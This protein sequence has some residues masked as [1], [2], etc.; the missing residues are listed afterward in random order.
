MSTNHS[1]I[2]RVSTQQQN[3]HKHSKLKETHKMH[4]LVNRM[5]KKTIK[6][7]KKLNRE[8]RR[9]IKQHLRLKIKKSMLIDNNQYLRSENEELRKK[10]DTIDYFSY[11][12][13]DIIKEIL[14]FADMLCDYNLR[15]L[16]KKF[17]NVITNNTKTIASQIVQKDVTSNNYAVAFH[18]ILLQKKMECNQKL[19]GKSFDFQLFGLENI[20][21]A[22]TYID[23]D[24]G[25]GNYTH[26]IWNL[27]HELPEF[28]KLKIIDINIRSIQLE[29]SI[30]DYELS[31]R[32][33]IP[34][35][36]T[37]N[38]NWKVWSLLYVINDI[39]NTWYQQQSGEYTL[40][41]SRKKLKKKIKLLNQLEEYNQMQ[42]AFLLH[43]LTTNS[44]QSLYYKAQS[45][46]AK[47][48]LDYYSTISDRND[49]YEASISRIQ[50]RNMAYI[51]QPNL[52]L[53]IRL[54]PF[55][56]EY[57][58]KIENDVDNNIDSNNEHKCHTDSSIN[59]SD[60][61]HYAP[62]FNPR[63]AIKILNKLKDE[64]A[65]EKMY[66]FSDQCNIILYTRGFYDNT[67]PIQIMFKNHS[68]WKDIDELL[69]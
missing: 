55:T 62:S 2:F 20:I 5:K 38:S 28:I 26:E 52:N 41:Q 46:I 37:N 61:E 9:V 69:N 42:Y 19:I 7:Y 27:F 68:L 48:Y 25:V 23:N 32:I 60:I 40:Y 54:V 63:N 16:S 11:V 39:I 64:I 47:K 29:V 4:S 65:K 15:T 6:E 67:E 21:N 31:E 14:T 12:P 8:R 57:K 3:M 33:S 66:N 30:K 56:Q 43:N 49:L 34:R 59:T 45:H 51:K 17:N 13:T 58:S 53:D 50:D 1:F 44:L 36:I 18:I 22:F 35:N 24:F 10:R